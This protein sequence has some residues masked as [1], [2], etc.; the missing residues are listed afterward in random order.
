MLG[1]SFEL[2]IEAPS[3][4]AGASFV[5]TEGKFYSD[6]IQQHKIVL[7]VIVLSKF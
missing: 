6:I 4:D 3:I 7:P 1:G 2:S 5:E